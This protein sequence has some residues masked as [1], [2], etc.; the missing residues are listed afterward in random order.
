MSVLFEVWGLEDRV[1][2]SLKVLFQYLKGFIIQCFFQAAGM[3]I[4]LYRCTINMNT[5]CME[6]KLDSNFTRMLWAVL[7]KS[8]KQ[9]PTKQQLYGYQPTIM[10]TIQIRW[11][12]LLEK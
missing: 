7:N 11:A 1:F 6:K 4:L 8:W 5:K 3:S 2:G 10:K 9:H 12:R